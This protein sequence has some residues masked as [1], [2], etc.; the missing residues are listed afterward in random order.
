MQCPNCYQETEQGK[1]CTNCGASI[2]TGD[3]PVTEE[4]IKDESEFE[5]QTQEYTDDSIQSNET[6]EKL[7][8]SSANFS[9][10]FLTIVK[11]P[12]EVTRANGND[13]LSGIISISLYSFL[14]ALG[15]YLLVDSFIN[16]FLGT[17]GNG[18]LGGRPKVQSLPFTDGFLWPFL[19]F[20][21]LFAIMASLTFAGL[22]LTTS[23]YSFQSIVAKYGGYL[24]PFSLLL[25]V[26]YILMFISL[27][28]IGLVAI[29]VSVVGSILLIPTFILLEQ[30]VS[31]I[32]RIYLLI[33]LYMLNILVTLFVL[34]SIFASALR[35]TPF[36]R[37]F[38]L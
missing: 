4:P 27:Y 21:I 36:S 38:G 16:T 13:F 6:L 24:I 37:M 22:K 7:K 8:E 29:V 35:F 14:F 20:I 33:I 11:K 15:Y 2:P 23:D 19:K 25:V 18:M 9:H 10:F 32:D 17:A 1:F 3:S 31:G 26:G 30:A 34:Q 5:Q 28:S 12:S